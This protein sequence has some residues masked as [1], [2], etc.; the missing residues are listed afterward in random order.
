[1]QS[2]RLPGFWLA[3][4]LLG[5]AA[6]LP[7]RASGDDQPPGRDDRPA[8]EAG[9]L[10]KADGY[11]GIWYMNQP[12]GD[13]Y[14]YKYSGGFAT[15]PQQ[16][17]PIAV[18]AADA[19]KTFFVYGGT[20]GNAAPPGQSGSVR[21]QLLHMVSYYDHA[22]HL[23]P[24]PTILLNKQTDDAHDNP[25]L[26][27]DAAGHLWVFSNAHGTSRPAYIHRS[28]RPYD[29]DDFE[30][31]TTTNFSYGQPWHV[32][33]RGFLL[34]HTRY[35]P[36]RQLFWMTSPDG[37]QWTEP[38]RLAAIEQG[39]YQV[40]WP[41]RDRLGTAFNFHPRQGGLNAR[42]NLYYVETPDLGRSWRSVDG[43]TVT[44]PIDRAD[45]PALVRDYQREGRLVYLKDLQY[46]AQGRP[47]ILYLTSGGYRPGPDSEPRQ[48]HTAHW[49]GSQWEILPF[50]RSDHNYDH[51]SLYIEDDG[52]WRVIAPTE[53]AVQPWNTGGEVW[54]WVS[55][56]QGRTWRTQRR[57]TGNSSREHGYVR[58]PL[59]AHPDFYALWADGLARR[60]SESR[61][62][63]TDRLGTQVWRLPERMQGETAAPEP[64]W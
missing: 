1:M 38:E 7:L 33:G 24:R 54:M 63:F 58:R 31:V 57:L 9:L 53:P 26:A 42:T 47:V 59:N 60:P 49:T 11:R 48:W 50:T 14:R 43:Q 8:G 27:L 16:H 44:P 46:D 20:T 51:G 23:V 28:R 17:M 52:T 41:W 6:G 61:L 3:W 62:Y 15:Y 40:S 29:I 39:H 12:T 37:L 34:L 10:P 4:G 56:D 19:H 22:A 35:A 25:T 64:A 18:Y 2:C 36:G 13:R 5:L 32:P 21:P 30:Q 45:H 55:R